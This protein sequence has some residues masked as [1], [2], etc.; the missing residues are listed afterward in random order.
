[1]GKV[2]LLILLI[3]I[4]VLNSCNISNDKIS[5]NVD[6]LI[7]DTIPVNPYEYF[8]ITDSYIFD[9]VWREYQVDTTNLLRHSI[10]ICD[11]CSFTNGKHAILIVYKGFRNGKVRTLEIYYA[12]STTHKLDYYREHLSD[13][14]AFFNNYG[15][16]LYKPNSPLVP[17]R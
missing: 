6:D 15:P 17:V 12:D 3:T 1:M 8:K 4:N 9:L 5:S 7:E 2:K 16:Y 13:S 10:Y 11:S 14:V